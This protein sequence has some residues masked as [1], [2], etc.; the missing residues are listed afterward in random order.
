[1]QTVPARPLRV[2]LSD[3]CCDPRLCL[4][5]ELGD[6]VMQRM[7]K[8]VHL[9]WAL[10]GLF[11]SG[12]LIVFGR[13]GGH[14]PA[15]ILLPAVLALWVVGHVLILATAWLARRG[16]ARSSRMNVQRPP[17]G[18]VIALILTGAIGFSGIVQIGGT[19]MMFD[20]YPYAGGLWWKALAVAIVHAIVFVGLLL[21]SSW[22]RWLTVFLAGSWGLI[23]VWSGLQHL[24]QFRVE[25]L[26]EWLVLVACLGLAA[27]L[28]YHF[29]VSPKIA[30]Y[31][32]S[33]PD[34]G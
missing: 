12:F 27:S 17:P 29:A 8:W 2:A 22:S 28:A 25:S 4:W 13:E 30:N 3:G 16:R 5:R 6:V 33:M 31:F 21:R 18:A 9:A 34:R 11:A 24:S 15:I 1:M 14:P 7:S 10:V 32:G 26:G 19:L 23:A 20:W